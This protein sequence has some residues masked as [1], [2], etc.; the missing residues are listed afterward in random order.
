LAAEWVGKHRE[1]AAFCVRQAQPVAIEAGFED[2]I[3]L[4][5]ICDD[6]LLVLL[7]PSSDHGD[8]DLE[9]HSRSSS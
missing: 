1:T 9:N 4:K 3:F 2:A 6:L 7:E 8:Q 5:E